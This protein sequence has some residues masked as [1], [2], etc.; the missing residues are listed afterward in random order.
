MFSSVPAATIS[1]MAG[2]A[3]LAAAVAS[4]ADVTTVERLLAGNADISAVA[5]E[6]RETALHFAARREPN[7][8][9]ILLSAGA[10][11]DS[12][13]TEGFTPLHAAAHAGAAQCLSILLAAPGVEACART[14]RGDSALHLAA[15][16]GCGAAAALLLDAAPALLD[17]RNTAGWTALM[18]AA[19]CAPIGSDAVCTLLDSGARDA[20]PR[21]PVD[22][23]WVC[24]CQCLSID[25]L[26]A[27]ARDAPPRPPVDSNAMLL[28]ASRGHAAAL[29]ALLQ[30][31]VGGGAAAAASA[32]QAATSAGDTPLLLAARSGCAG[33]VRLLLRA[34][35]DVAARNV[36][37]RS[38]A[39]RES[40]Y[41][42]SRSGA[43]E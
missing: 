29:R 17:D 42:M 27:G 15:I 24:S 25:S 14:S 43:E 4:G 31:L 10:S 38:G 9:S 19:G 36:H 20:P 28:A 13:C 26:L 2:A 6:R 37:R 5:G 33:S 3:N 40:R 30:R 32:T 21:P 23:R 22:S 8:T 16:S 39:P 7:L 35:A 1:Y 41:R 18:L 11:L 34:H 12:T